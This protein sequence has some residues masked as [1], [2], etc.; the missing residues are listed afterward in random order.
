[1]GADGHIDIFDYEKI[2]KHFG[3][4]KANNFLMNTINTYVHDFLGQ[5][6]MTGY[7]GDNIFD[8]WCSDREEGD[9]EELREM[10]EWIEK[11]AKISTWE[12]WT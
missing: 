1:M 11:N 4:E 9:N 2:E 5:K 10:L 6:I 8:S 3:K 12:V 7:Y